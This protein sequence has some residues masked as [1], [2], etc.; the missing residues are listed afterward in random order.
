MVDRLEMNQVEYA[1]HRGVTK[2]AINKLVGNGKIALVPSIADP[3]R[4]VIDVVATDL[5]L[6]ETRERIASLVDD[7]SA[8][9][10][11]DSAA[12]PSPTLTA[13]RTESEIYRAR[14]SQ[15]EYEQK[16]GL[17]L[18]ADDVAAAAR[19]CGE[20]LARDLESIANS[21]GE[22][23]GAF[24]QGGEVEHRAVL[25]RAVHRAQEQLAANLRALA[26]SATA[27]AAA[28]S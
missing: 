11:A 12:S 8:A 9:P 3:H 25:K 6:G 7:E 5:A 26:E 24:R 20:Q 22:L 19:Q 14:L 15:L 21:S 18:R 28:G 16:V 4:M 23:V 27:S 10:G 13:A 17:L 1:A 2:Q